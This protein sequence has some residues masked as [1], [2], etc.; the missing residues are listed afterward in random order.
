MKKKSAQPIIPSCLADPVWLHTGVKVPVFIS[1]RRLHDEYLH[2]LTDKS[3]N[4]RQGET[5]QHLLATHLSREPS[6][7]VITTERSGGKNIINK[8]KH[9]IFLLFFSSIITWDLSQRG[10]AENPT[11]GEKVD[12]KLLLSRQ[13]CYGDD[14]WQRSRGFYELRCHIKLRRVKCGS[15]VTLPQVRQRRCGLHPSH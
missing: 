1:M 9:W 8:L 11:P 13:K 5:L 3:C 6:W 7:D 12:R 2:Q 14:W 10:G 4:A 15:L